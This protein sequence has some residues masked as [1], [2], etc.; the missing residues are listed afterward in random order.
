MGAAWVQHGRAGFHISR[1]RLHACGNDMLPCCGIAAGV[2]PPLSPS[3][4]CAGMPLHRLCL[5]VCSVVTCCRAAPPMWSPSTRSAMCT[6]RAGSGRRP[7]LVRGGSMV[8]AVAVCGCLLPVSCMLHSTIALPTGKSG[9]W[10]EALA[11]KMRINAACCWLVGGH[12]WLRDAGPAAALPTGKQRQL[13]RAVADRLSVRP[14]PAMCTS[15]IKFAGGAAP[16]GL[17]CPTCLMSPAC[18]QFPLLCCSSGGDAAGAGAA[19][20][21]H[22]QHHHDCLQHLGA[23]A[24]EGRACA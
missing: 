2:L 5:P 24:G 3:A 12:V 14:F 9:Q 8:L 20:D 21:P 10:E 23:V 7:L 18:F 19:C 17:I 16:C 22:L 15:A 11:G 13:E 4:P 6:A 1:L